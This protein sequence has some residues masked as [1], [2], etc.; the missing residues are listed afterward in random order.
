MVIIFMLFPVLLGLKLGY[1][2][3]M[4]VVKIY[5]AAVSKGPE[6]LSQNPQLFPIL[7]QFNPLHIFKTSFL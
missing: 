1:Y 2:H 3:E 4:F 7:Y 5:S 6:L